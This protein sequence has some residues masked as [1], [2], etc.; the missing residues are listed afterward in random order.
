M[1]CSVKREIQQILVNLRNSIPESA[2]AAL[3]RLER[4][5]GEVRNEM[6][7]LKSNLET[8]NSSNSF[9]KAERDKLSH[10]LYSNECELRTVK[11]DLVRS[12]KLIERQSIHIEAIANSSQSIVNTIQETLCEQ[13]NGTPVEFRL[14]GDVNCI[15]QENPL[16]KVAVDLLSVRAIFDLRQYEDLLLDNR[17]NFYSEKLK[18]CIRLS[19]IDDLNL[20]L[21]VLTLDELNREVCD[22]GIELEI[23]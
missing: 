22:T 19:L 18:L 12:Q 23:P 2:K 8:A 20:V 3:D 11:N 9:L 6:S 16:M 15:V 5:F 7:A 21:T 14:T 4:L 1:R 10:A 13:W 17:L